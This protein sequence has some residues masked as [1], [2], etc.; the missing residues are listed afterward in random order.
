MLPSSSQSRRS[1]RA[2]RS[3]TA[4]RSC[5]F[6]SATHRSHPM[7]ESTRARPTWSSMRRR[8]TRGLPRARCTK[9]RSCPTLRSRIGDSTSRREAWRS[10]ARSAC[11]ASCLR[12]TLRRSSDDRGCSRGT[13][14][15]SNSTTRPARRSPWEV[16]R[17][18]CLVRSRSNVDLPP[19]AGELERPFAARSFERLGLVLRVSRR[20]EDQSQGHR[21]ERPGGE[22][23]RA[24]QATALGTISSSRRKRPRRARSTS[25]RSSGH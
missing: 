9:P 16:S 2:L 10:R 15:R 18:S 5:R 20:L 12:P 4:I 13:A 8:P 14:A 23:S 3:M 7:L 6:P 21:A 19:R 17:S 1:A 25:M 22:S 24:A 11:T